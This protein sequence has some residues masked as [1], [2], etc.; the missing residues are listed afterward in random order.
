MGQE[1]LGHKVDCLA[2]ELIAMRVGGPARNDEHKKLAAKFDQMAA[3]FEAMQLLPEARDLH[4]ATVADR[5]LGSFGSLGARARA[6]EAQHR[7]SARRAAGDSGRCV[8]AGAPP[9]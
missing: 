1:Q 8:G 6:P 5:I 3:A 4:S 9:R 7:D 2:R